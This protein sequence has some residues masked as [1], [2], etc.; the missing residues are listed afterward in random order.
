MSGFLMSIAISLFVAFTG[1]KI[2]RS[3]MPGGPWVTFLFAL[4]GSWIGGYMKI[5]KGAGIQYS[6][7]NI[8]PAIIGSIIFVFI[9]GFFR[10]TIAKVKI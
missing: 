1:D 2:V 4:M 3:T 5:F 7:L 10:K 8:I 9:Y 6:E